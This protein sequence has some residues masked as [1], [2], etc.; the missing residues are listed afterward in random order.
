[1]SNIKINKISLLEPTAP[2]I[3]AETPK[4]F[5]LVPE[6]QLVWIFGHTEL[7]SC[8]PVLEGNNMISLDKK[9]GSLKYY[10]LTLTVSD[11]WI[12]WSNSSRNNTITFLLKLLLSTED[13]KGF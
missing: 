6:H 11:T 9:L 7:Q 13:A 1:M 5:L 10:I 4:E 3:V 2:V 8:L 12:Y